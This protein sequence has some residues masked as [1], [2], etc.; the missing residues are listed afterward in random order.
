[1]FSPNAEWGQRA[2]IAFKKQW[3]SQGGVLLEP[4]YLQ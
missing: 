4:S 3:L 1:M 2:A